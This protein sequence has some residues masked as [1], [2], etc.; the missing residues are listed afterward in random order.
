MEHEGN[1][2]TSNSQIPWNNPKETGEIGDQLEYSQESW[3]TENTCCHLDSSEGIVI[4]INNDNDEKNLL[5]K[6]GIILPISQSCL[7]L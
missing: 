1:G 6:F 4:F 7:I 3:R 2:D 5:F